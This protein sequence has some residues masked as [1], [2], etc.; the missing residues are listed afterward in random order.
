MAA[1]NPFR[2]S[3]LIAKYGWKVMPY[4]SNLGPL[5]LAEA[6]VIFVDSGHVNALD[7][8]DT[9]HGHSF[10]KPLD[11]IDY[12]VDLCTA[13][14]RSVILVAPGHNEPLDASS[15][16]FDVSDITVIGIGEGSNR[17]TINFDSTDAI[18]S[19]GANNVHLRNLRFVPSVTDV[20]IGVDVETTITGTIIEDC[21]FAEGD[22]I[23]ADEFITALAI[24]AT[25]TDTRVKNCLFRTGLA[26]DGAVE[27]IKLTGISD[28]VVI[29]KSRFI[30]NWSVA[31]I[32][33]DSGVC[34]DLL[35]DDCT[36]KVADGLPGV[37]VVSTT[38]G[39][40]RNVCIESTG[41]AVDSMIVAAGMS[42]FN[43]YGVT[44]DGT[45]AEIIGGG[46][47]Q[48]ALVTYN[49]DHLMKT[50]T[51]DTDDKVDIVEVVDNTVLAH[52]MTDDGD[53]S[54]YD[55]RVHSLEA[56]ANI[57]Q[58]LLGHV[59][60]SV[61]G[62]T[63]PV[64]FWWVDAN[65]SDDN[66]DGKT[67]E[68]AKQTITAVLTLCEDTQDDWIFVR[69]YSGNPNEITIANSFVHIIGC[70]L[71]GMPYPRF[72]AVASGE[73]AFVL[74]DAADRVEIAY[75]VLASTGS[76]A[77]VEFNGAAGSY[78][79]WIHD[80]VIGRS[81][82]ACQ[83]GVRV[84]PGGAAPYLV[85]ENC[86]FGSVGTSSVTRDGIR[87]SGNATGGIIRNNTFHQVAGIG[88]NLVANCESITV[89]DNAFHLVADGIGDAVDVASGCSNCLVTGNRAIF[90]D[91]YITAEVFRDQGIGNDFG[92]NDDGLD[93]RTHRMLDAWFSYANKSVVGSAFPR[94]FWYVDANITSSGNGRTPQTAFKTIQE[95][96]DVCSNSTDD[97]VFVFDYSGT[98]STITI[99]TAYIHL[100]GN[101]GF[102][103]PYPRIKPDSGAGIELQDGADR[104]E[105]CGFT[106]GAADQSNS[107]IVFDGDAAAGAYGCYIHDN[108]I[109]R[110][111][112]APCQYGIEVEAGGAAPYLRIS[113]NRFF[114][115]GGAGIVATGSAILLTGNATR[116][117]IE[118]NRIL[119]VG[120]TA[121][122]A[123]WL[124]GGITEPT[125]IGNH[126]KHDTDSGT[127]GAITLGASVD[128]GWICGNFACDGKDDSSQNP[129]LDGASTNGWAG[130]YNGATITQPA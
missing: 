33:N 39:I 91:N 23:A 12:A 125:I 89:K 71:P 60:R 46:E 70:A 40:I 21:E 64:K 51:A 83:D 16:D 7:A 110:D 53:M 26:A 103:M 15:I 99:D 37:S 42:W 105:I 38:T 128:D 94:R 92:Q 122:P 67:P 107:A 35:I 82:N 62:T 78:G 28:N 6:Q 118:N 19:I 68:T 85:V 48:A 2:V 44:V 4:L 54:D 93:W 74:G 113:N 114:G 5:L 56:I 117:V 30:G 14:E 123:I 121:T 3:D 22:D 116:C 109:G 65:A 13:A 115:A 8:D 49:L 127:G 119:D 86:N 108:V 76:A 96:I 69:D 111:A 17:P 95:A 58:A 41:L 27:A 88:V 52:L 120:R 130:N 43:N 32:Y 9:E 47:V 100:V 25:C 10:E 29:E 75:C 36:M 87:F 11:T 1:T 20:V 50:A 90:G 45:A 80:C 55:R 72:Q 57:S 18:V 101:M 24:K 66:G 129:F 104:V 61:A 31:A 81:G 73:A 77:A 97:W 126:I 79:C 112:D 59:M 124:A 63:F 34:T 106:I 84:M 98:G 102:A